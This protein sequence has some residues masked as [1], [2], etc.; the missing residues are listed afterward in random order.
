MSSTAR[1]A[2]IGQEQGLS[3]ERQCDLWG[4]SHSFCYYVPL[5]DSK[6][7]LHLMRLMDEK[8]LEMPF[9][10]Y[11]LMWAHLRTQGYLV[12]NKRIRRLYHKM[13]IGAIYAKPKLSQPHPEH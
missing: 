1:R 7:N 9:Y 5:G 6:E 2:L 10:G 11:R 13:G 12:N 8:Y 4:L 3:I